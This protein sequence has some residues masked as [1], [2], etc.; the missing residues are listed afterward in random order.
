MVH[1]Q[2]G[3][4]ESQECN[5]QKGRHGKTQNSMLH[6]F[7]YSK[8]K[9]LLVKPRRSAD[10][11]ELAQLSKICIWHG[12]EY[13]ANFFGVNTLL[14]H[15]LY[16]TCEVAC[17]RKSQCTLASSVG[18]AI[19]HKVIELLVERHKTG[20]MAQKMSVYAH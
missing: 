19:N 11:Q 8:L 17:L 18:C 3:C 14:Y 16:R 1:L 13:G 6:I 12:T 20:T 2:E 7:P 5:V 15:L 9:W 10:I 4:E